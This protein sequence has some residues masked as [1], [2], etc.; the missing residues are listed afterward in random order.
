MVEE[1]PHLMTYKKQRAGRGQKAGI[2]FEGTLSARV[3]VARPCLLNLE[4][5]GFHF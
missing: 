3:P 1:P 5:K 4:G 2:A